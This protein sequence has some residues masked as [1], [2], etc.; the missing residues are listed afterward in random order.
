MAL[1]LQGERRHPIEHFTQRDATERGVEQ[2]IRRGRPDLTKQLPRQASHEGPGRRLPEVVA[3]GAGGVEVEAAVVRMGE[4]VV[5]EGVVV[6]LPGKREVVAPGLGGELGPLGAT[7]PADE[8]GNH[9]HRHQFGGAHPEVLLRVALWA[10]QG[11]GIVKREQRRRR[12]IAGGV[13][14]RAGRRGRLQL[15]GSRTGQDDQRE[16]YGRARDE[17]HEQVHPGVMGSW[18][19]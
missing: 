18:T 8:V 1:V 14:C 13:E 9:V 10:R 15:C 12:H 7:G 6:P 11:V 16:C 2:V 19:C 3:I 5:Q 4:L 17:S